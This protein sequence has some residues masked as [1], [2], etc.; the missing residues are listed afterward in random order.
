MSGDQLSHEELLERY[1]KFYAEQNAEAF[2]FGSTYNTVVMGAGYV[3][4]FAIWSNVRAELSPTATVWVAA[5]MGVSLIC[6]VGFTVVQMLAMAW[7]Q[8]RTASKL[9]GLNGQA[10]ITEY[11][12]LK[13][14]DETEGTGIQI[15]WAITA[16]LAILTAAIAAA[17]LFYS[18][19]EYLFCGPDCIY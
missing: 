11:L 14:L 6:F 13:K 9:K 2:R 18:F 8:H 16:S 5:L 10:Y 15:F 3:G 1:K 12:R 19:S 4:A 7:W 17:I